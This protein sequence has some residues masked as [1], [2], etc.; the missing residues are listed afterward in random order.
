MGL[1]AS[2]AKLPAARRPSICLSQR[3]R[4]AEGLGLATFYGLTA[5]CLGSSAPARRPGLARARA[6]ARALARWRGSRNESGPTALGSE[7]SATRDPTNPATTTAPPNEPPRARPPGNRRP[8]P[9]PRPFIS[10]L[11]LRALARAKKAEATSARA[12]PEGGRGPSA[13]LRLCEKL[14][15]PPKPPPRSRP[16]PAGQPPPRGP[17][18][19]SLR[20]RALARAQRP[21][22]PKRAQDHSRVTRRALMVAR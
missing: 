21:K 14:F 22:S 13:P 5:G 8:A 18:I 3:R 16:E 2:T 9:T 7:P 20:L 12:Q 6:P 1:A 15:A 11:R 19:S 4:D 10:S 17:F